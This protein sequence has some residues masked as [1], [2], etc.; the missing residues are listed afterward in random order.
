MARKITTS[1]VC[2]A[3]LA[4]TVPAAPALAGQEND[5]RGARASSGEYQMQSRGYTVAKTQGLTQYWWHDGRRACV[6]TVTSDGRYAI[7]DGASDSDCG[8]G[9]SSAGAAIAGIAAIGLIAALASHKKR[10]N[11]RY[12]TPTHNGEFERGYND[13][14]YGSEY[15]RNDSETYHDGYM[16]GETERQNRTAANRSQVR[17]VPPMASQACSRRADD[18]FGV[19]PGSS[20]PIS[21][22]NYGQGEYDLTMAAGRYRAHCSVS[23]RGQ[24]RNMTAGN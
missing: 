16:A 3:V 14:L 11:N 2:I 23:A 15:D 6:R 24:I 18:F 9:G 10:T 8:K 19:S 12:D 5:L 4:A 22:Y 20:V 13:G 1:F 7:V 17:G 21:M